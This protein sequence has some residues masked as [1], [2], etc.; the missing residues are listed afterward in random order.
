LKIDSKPDRDDPQKVMQA[1]GALVIVGDEILHLNR[2]VVVASN[3]G[4]P[5]PIDPSVKD[6][7]ADEITDVTQLKDMK[8]DTSSQKAY[9]VIITGTTLTGAEVTPAPGDNVS[10]MGK[11]APQSDARMKVIISAPKDSKKVGLTVA[12]PG[13][14]AAGVT[15][16]VDLTKK[17][18]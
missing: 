14:A 15:F 6:V 3:E 1:L 10:V 18:Q 2:E 12:R 5:Q 13:G 4:G 7:S 11:P 16:Q 8:V 17:P 9:S